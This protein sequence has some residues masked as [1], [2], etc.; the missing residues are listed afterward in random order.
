MLTR[1]QFHVLVVG[2]AAQAARIDSKIAGVMIGAQS[3]SFRDRP[4][5]DALAAYK[6][7]GLGYCELWSGHVE[8]RNLSREELRNWRLTVSLDH[9]R[10]V[11]KKFD[12]AGVELYAYSYNF[13]DDFTDEEIARGFEMAQALGVTVITASANVSTVRRID[14]YA[15]KARIRV[16]MHNHSNLRPNEFARPEDFAEAMR[17]ASPYIAINLD[18]G[19]FV[20]AGYDPVDFIGKHHDRIVS[21]HIKDRKKNQGPNVPFG[22]GDTPIREVL[23]L[24]KTRKYPIPAMIEYEY[25]GVDTVAEVRRCFEYCKRA[26]A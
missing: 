2:G 10:S 8:P 9:F 3:Y 14:P 18:I 12:E 13:R 23:Q 25:K 21:L 17:G 26:L 24:L 19:H 16:G 7:I 4:L 22:E 11:R 1:R 5:D 15:A 6:E 20:A